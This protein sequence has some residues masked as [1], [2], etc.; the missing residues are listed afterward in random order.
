[1]KFIHTADIHLDTCFAGS[2]M[3][4]ALGNRRRQS[5]RDVLHAIV[6]RAGEWPADALLIAGD[7]FEGDRVSQDTILFLQREFEAIAPVPVFIAPGNHDPYTSHS[8]YATETWPENVFIF[9]SPEW[10]CFGAKDGQLQVHGFAFDGPVVSENPF[11]SLRIV[12]DDAVHIAIGHGSERGHQPPDKADYAPFD[13][14]KAAV[15]GLSYLGLGHF[16][17]VTPI[18]GDFDTTMYY[19]GAPEG[20][21]FR[22]TGIHHFLEVEIITGEVH[23]KKV[24]SSRLVYVNSSVA[25]E[26]LTTSQEVLDAIRAMASKT[27]TSCMARVTLTGA[28]AP[29]ILSELGAV[30]DAC[31]NDFE[32]LDIIDQTDP[33]EDYKDLARDPTSIG[34]FV[35]ALN[36]DIAQ[37]T[38]SVRRLM[39]ERARELGVAAFRGMDVEIRGLGRG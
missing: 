1:M 10:T 12:G 13:A 18:E 34:A 38:D 14:A 17:S 6:R 37:T 20:H 8:P 33:Q 39:L 36:A 3:P 27:D 23:V 7:L 24:P 35:K 22:E 5:L 21:G 31:A 32:F 15:K 19:S 26:E 28:C 2:G 9:E 29:N 30:Y 25:C 11:G 16:H 4:A